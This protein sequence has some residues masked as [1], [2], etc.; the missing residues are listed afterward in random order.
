MSKLSW[1]RSL[2]ALLLVGLPCVGAGCSWGP[3]V[4]VE[5]T[6]THSIP[7]ADINR[8]IVETHNGGVSA[9]GESGRADVAVT[10]KIRGG[11]KTR[12]S[13]EACLAAIEL[14]SERSGTVDHRLAW[15]W[16]KTRHDDWS[17]DV[18]YRIIAPSRLALD[19]D[20]H[21]GGVTVR[22]FAGDCRLITHNGGVKAEGIA[23]RLH[24]HT[25]NGGISASVSGEHVVL[26]THNGGVH[27]DAGATRRIGGEV[28]SHNGGLRIDLGK[29][30]ATELTCE[31]HNGG[32]NCSADLKNMHAS[33]T[34]VFG[35]LGDGGPPLT[36]RT[37]NG[38]VRIVQN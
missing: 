38:G 12:K 10:A 32:L 13:A 19:V 23:G 29:Q 4:W 30:T 27:L 16:T 3:K 2:A 28:T 35:Q 7:A 15:R 14:I 18:A 9:L 36:V 20:T 1:S 33:R 25:H 17:A 11:G 26:Q 21:N 6:E 24:A 22:E 5:R 31:T 34:R 37:Y 8:L